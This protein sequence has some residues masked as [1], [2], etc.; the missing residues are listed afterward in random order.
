MGWRT[1]AIFTL[2]ATKVTLLSAVISV[3][4]V[5]QALAGIVSGELSW[6]WLIV[7]PT[8]AVL[9]GALLTSLLGRSTGI[10]TLFVSPASCLTASYLQFA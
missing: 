3:V 5:G 2:P 7:I 4:L 10:V 8:S 9:G 1:G 6:W